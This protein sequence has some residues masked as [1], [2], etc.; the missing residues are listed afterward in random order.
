MWKLF[1]IEQPN[2]EAI[3][4]IFHKCSHIIKTAEWRTNNVI[5]IGNF[6]VANEQE[7][8]KFF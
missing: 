6:F 8:L 5:K 7:I 3:M 4:K 2:Y 1:K